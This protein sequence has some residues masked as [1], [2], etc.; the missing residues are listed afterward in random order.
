MDVVDYIVRDM[1][2]PVMALEEFTGGSYDWLFRFSA[3]LAFLFLFL[4]SISN[5]LSLFF[6]FCVPLFEIG[7]KLNGGHFEW[8][9]WRIGKM[10]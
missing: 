7:R 3:R 1:N 6:S 2:I 10:A 4:P 5:L 8:L 9:E